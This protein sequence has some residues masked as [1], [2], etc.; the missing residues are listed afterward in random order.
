M[1]RCPPEPPAEVLGRYGRDRHQCRVLSLTGGNI[2]SSFLVSIGANTFVLQRIAENVFSSPAQVIENSR[3]VCQHLRRAKRNWS[4]LY[5]IAEPWPTLDGA[6]AC[7]D[8]SGGY[9]RAL[10]Y[11]PNTPHHAVSVSFEK[12]GRLLAVFHSIMANFDYSA[13]HTV[14][15][16]FHDLGHYLQRLDVVC[17]DGGVERSSKTISGSEK[18]LSQCLKT[19]DRYRG[20][21]DCFIKQLADGDIPLQ[22][23]HGD[24]KLENFLF[25][26]DGSPMSLIDLDTVGRGTI[27]HD[28]GDCLRSCCNLSGESGEEPSFDIQRCSEIISGY[29][30]VAGNA[31][32]YGQRRCIFDGVRMITFE[33]GVRFLTDFLE[34]NP[35]FL[36][37]FPEENLHRALG[38]FSL[39]ESITEQ[40][41]AILALLT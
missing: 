35:Y 12:V 2:N 25:N 22:T 32:E 29:L 40:E 20:A 11:I 19:V 17:V 37:S 7:R 30:A 31:M 34:G 39:L 38:Q 15:P 4:Q 6:L 18:G 16:G 26:E 36:V 23:V 24:P 27:F 9:W 5:S 13:L 21:A 28:I 10:L 41:N 8:D 1:V 33:L 14:I 3:L